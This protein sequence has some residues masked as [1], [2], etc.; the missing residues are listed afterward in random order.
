MRS[1]GTVPMA[2][3]AAPPGA[4]FGAVGNA[5]ARSTVPMA[6]ASMIAL[7]RT[8]GAYSCRMAGV[9]ART[10]WASFAASQL[11]NRMQPW[12]AVRP[13]VSGRGVPWIP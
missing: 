5:T 12:D 4:M 11:V 9:P 6:A 13:T 10:I 8:G 3:W 7:A 2:I 1:S